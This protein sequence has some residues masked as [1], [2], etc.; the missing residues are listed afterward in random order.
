MK[1]R[2]WIC[3]IA[4]TL[5]TAL[6][7]PVRLAAQEQLQTNQLPRYAVID[8]GTLGGSLSE[9]R[10]VNNKGRVTG[11]AY[12]AGNAAQ[13]RV[14]W[15]N[16]VKTDLGTLGGPNSGGY[17]F[18]GLN[19]NGQDAGHAE[20]SSPDPLGE[21]FC[22]FGT[23]LICLPF[24]WQDG[25]MTPLSTLGGSN[26]GARAVNNRSQ[27]AGEA[28]NTTLDS[29]CGSPELEAEP[30]IWENGAIHQLP[31]FADDPDGLA[32]AINDN[33]QVVGGSGDCYTGS[34][35]SLHALIWQTGRAT[36]LGS[37]GGTLY[38]IA[39]GINDK[40]QVTGSSDL[41]GDTS[42]F[43]GGPASTSHAFL[44]QNGVMTDLGTL[45]G[46]AQSFGLG[47]NNQGQIVGGFISRAYI[48][49]NGVMTDLN[50]LV[51]GPPFSP[52][53]L[54]AAESI[55]DRGEI[56]GTGLAL[57]GDQHA[58][59]ALPCDAEHAGVEAC[60]LGANPGPTGG[61]TEAAPAAA[62]VGSPGNRKPSV[63]PGRVPGQ[64]GD[65][66][67]RGYRLRAPGI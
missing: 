25:V 51:P 40:G 11:T 16:G 24:L 42:F 17:G 43:S 60:K 28:E 18:G 29:T 33:G 59:L 5:Y 62:P 37:F 39:L 9:G 14:I 22:G 8:L 35:L 31:T 58:F 67:F 10:G 52:L 46:D 6:A 2:T 30:V 34:T 45:P 56:T 66:R 4:V 1:S 44:W 19:D 47:I 65:Q 20:T 26:G 48:W 41:P 55:N 15:Q 23:Q 63:A 12:L 57:D 21:D 3:I 7:N 49:Q 53:Y 27:V 61:P 64:M 38:N 36:N 50:T 54:L 32:T 13:H